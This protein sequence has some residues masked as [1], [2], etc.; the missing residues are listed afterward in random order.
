MD[1]GRA[2][3]ARKLRLLE[4]LKW[5]LMFTCAVYVVILLLTAKKAPPIVARL[6]LRKF[7]F[8]GG[9]NGLYND[10][11]SGEILQSGPGED[12]ILHVSNERE[13]IGGGDHD[14]R[15]I[16]V[17]EKEIEGVEVSYPILKFIFA[18]LINF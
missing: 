9:Y 8:L 12:N 14:K 10:T 11:E 15:K 2:K 16:L 17:V 1:R 4:E 13:E 5:I 6:F 7:E 18:F 3:L